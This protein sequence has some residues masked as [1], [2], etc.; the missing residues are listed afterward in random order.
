MDDILTK[1]DLLKAR[2]PE[3]IGNVMNALLLTGAV[4]SLYG[5]S[6]PISGAEHHMSHYWEVLGE[7]RG[8]QFAM[9]G[10]QVAVGTVMA[11]SVAERLA[12]LTPDFDKARAAAKQ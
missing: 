1:T 2:D 8:Q 7:Q 4:I 5:N 10:E 3:A 12:G 11:L 9:H 6:R